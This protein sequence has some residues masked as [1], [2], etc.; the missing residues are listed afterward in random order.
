MILQP[1]TT[2]SKSSETLLDYKKKIWKH[3]ERDEQI[4][5]KNIDEIVKYRAGI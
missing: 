1:P 3:K 4:T 5:Q 2:I